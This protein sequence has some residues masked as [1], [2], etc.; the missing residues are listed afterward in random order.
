MGLN[1]N[2]VI[3]SSYRIKIPI[4]AADQAKTGVYDLENF[5]RRGLGVNAAPGGLNVICIGNN[6]AALDLNDQVEDFTI[7]AECG[8]LAV[9]E[10]I[11]SSKGYPSIQIR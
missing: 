1:F 11:S 9:N 8:V 2:H 7:P 4:L 6:H 5:A 3:Q 10:A